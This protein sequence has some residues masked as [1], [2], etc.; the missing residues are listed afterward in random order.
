MRSRSLPG[1]VL[2]VL[3][4]AV[5]ASAPAHAA[6]PTA[7]ECIA[8]ADDGQKLRDDG[9]LSAARDKLLACASKGCPAA[10]SKDCTQW[11]VDIDRDM[12]SVSFRA[13]DGTGSEI[14]DVRV[15][16]D[17]AMLAESIEAHSVP[18]DPG[19]YTVRFERKDGTS[20]E[21][22]IVLRPGEKN[23]IVELVFRR[24]SPLVTAPPLV[25][26]PPVERPGGGFRV[27]WIAWVGLGVAVLGGVGTAAFAVLAKDDERRLRATCAPSCLP[28]ERGGVETK[29][30]LANVSLVVAA[31]GL[32][33]AVVSTIFAN[34]GRK[35]IQGT[36]LVIGPA[37]GG[38]VV[39]AYGTF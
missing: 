33:T 3:A 20:V 11:L 14:V 7:K 18:L 30:T 9:K 13:K 39:G 19:K 21:D 29:V 2:A 15:L 25:T 36:A 6:K 4:A 24:S 5:L 28:S 34:L 38:A 31:V 22:T 8:A 32:G 23:R 26:P 17:G 27:P 12:P 16:V 1:L 10:I 37:L 35:P